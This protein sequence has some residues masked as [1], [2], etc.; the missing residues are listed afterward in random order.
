[1]LWP[2]LMC[3]RLAGTDREL[4]ATYPRR[5]DLPRHF[6]RDMMTSAR[7]RMYFGGYTSYFLW[8]DVPQAH[9]Y[10]AAK[11]SDG[12]DIR[13]LLGD[14]DSMVTRARDDVESHP[15]KLATRINMTRME[16]ARSG[17]A[18]LMPVRLSDR[19]IGTSVWIFDDEAVLAM[20]IGAGLGHDSLTQHFRQRKKEGPFSRLLEHFE[21]LWADARPAATEAPS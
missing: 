14:P 6:W 20:H 1:M 18:D 19:H 2:E 9:T 4:V 3:R 11:A 7:Q 13:W 10:L 8:L 21:G 12:V 17:A 5:A 15:L 16:V